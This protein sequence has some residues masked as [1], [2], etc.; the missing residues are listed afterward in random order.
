MI[1]YVIYQFSRLLRVS[2]YTSTKAVDQI[3]VLHIIILGVLELFRVPQIL[4]FQIEI[5]KWK[6]TYTLM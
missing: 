4:R 5:N 2:I 6:Y 1:A 3:L